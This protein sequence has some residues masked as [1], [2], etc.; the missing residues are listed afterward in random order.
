MQ[1]QEE[2]VFSFDT[3]MD[4]VLFD[5]GFY[6]EALALDLASGSL[7]PRLRLQ[8]YFG[9]RYMYMGMQIE[10]QPT[11]GPRTLTPTLGGRTT[12]TRT[13]TR[14]RVDSI[15]ITHRCVRR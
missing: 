12:T 6:W 9:G 2:Q 10:V 14:M 15:T 3:V 5:F 7:P 11:P 1:Q 13:S 8:P 4:F